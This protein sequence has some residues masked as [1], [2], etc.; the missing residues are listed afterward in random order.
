[1]MYHLIKHRVTPQTKHT[2]SSSNALVYFQKVVLPLFLFICRW[3]VQ[4]YTIQRQ[5]KRN[6]GSTYRVRAAVA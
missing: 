5:I 2:I 6:G 4:N 3:I 1:M